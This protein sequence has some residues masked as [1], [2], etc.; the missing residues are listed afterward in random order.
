ML[1]NHVL[2]AQLL[3]LELTESMVMVYADHT[4]ETLAKLRALG[5]KLAID[6][7]GT[8]YSSLDYLRKFPVDRIKI[9]QSFIRNIK[10]IP[11]NDAIV[12][13]IIAMGDNLGMEMIAEGVETLDELECIKNHHCQEVQGY[14]FSRPVPADEFGPWFQQ[15]SRV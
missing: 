14:H 3:E 5:I 15:F 12:R 1:F 7:F 8:G 6:D 4:V 11:A 10:T 2:P 13:A 9:D